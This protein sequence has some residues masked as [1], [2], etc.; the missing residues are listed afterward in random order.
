M[1]VEAVFAERAALA[2]MRVGKGCGR[3]DIVAIRGEAVAQTEKEAVAFVLLNHIV[4]TADAEIGCA[5][6]EVVIQL[7]S[8]VVAFAK[9][10]FEDGEV[11]LEEIQTDKSLKLCPVVVGNFKDGT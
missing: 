4:V 11:F 6:L 10:Q 5:H 3:I 1:A 2:P 8:F 7:L 9:A